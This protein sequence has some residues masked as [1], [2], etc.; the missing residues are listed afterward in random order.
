MT[1]PVCFK[2]EGTK[3]EN[4]SISDSGALRSPF[5]PKVNSLSQNQK[6]AIENPLHFPHLGAT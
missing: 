5:S 6:R 3:A 1:F 2:I 4:W